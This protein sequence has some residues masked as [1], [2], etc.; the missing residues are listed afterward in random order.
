LNVEKSHIEKDFSLPY[1]RIGHGQKCAVAFHGFGQDSTYFSTFE[2][3]LSKSYT[4]YSFDLP[5]HGRHDLEKVDQP[6]DKD[7]LRLFFQRFLD[8]EKITEFLNI[9]FSIGA[10]L[11]LAL[12][13]F[14]PEKIERMVL[15]APDGFRT[16]IWYKLATGSQPTRSVFKHMV[17]NPDAFFKLS[18][19][20][21]KMNFVHPGVSRFA[22]SQ[23]S[24]EQKREKVYF[25]WMF[26]RKLNYKK[27]QILNSLIKHNIPISVFLGSEDK[28][29]Q[30]KQFSFLSED[31]E[32]NFELT[33]L[34]AGHNNLI[35][36]TANYLLKTQ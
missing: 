9:G 17:Y 27:S 7:T 10:K 6:I 30:K 23:M 2:P 22:R 14:F 26:F 35:E 36:E 34:P 24:S 28:I 11:S 13:E 19:A 4:I 18:D 20:M 5:Y 1:I 33:E 15:I 12:L 32:V 16:N 25:T 29:I 31:Q 21:A 8:A 3:V